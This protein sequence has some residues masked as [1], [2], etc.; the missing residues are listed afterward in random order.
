MHTVICQREREKKKANT[1]NKGSKS[2]RR[3]R[4]SRAATSSVRL[5][6][7]PATSSSS[8]ESR[9]MQFISKIFLPAMQN[10]INWNVAY[11]QLSS[12]K[13]K[14]RE[15]ENRPFRSTVSL[16]TERCKE[17]RTMPEGSMATTALDHCLCCCRCCCESFLVGPQVPR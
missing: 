4:A 14:K 3:R 17:G 6:T 11:L 7:S 1:R 9:H 13:K 8:A 5:S 16:A 2:K 15:R 12:V 10:E